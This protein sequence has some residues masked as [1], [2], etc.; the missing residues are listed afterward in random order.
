MSSLVISSNLPSH[1]PTPRSAITRRTCQLVALIFVLSVSSLPGITPQHTC[2]A[3]EVIA[4]K[5]GKQL[6]LLGD[7]LVEAQ[8]GSLLFRTADGKLWIV[9]SDQV[10]SKNE[11]TE[12]VK[13]LSQTAIGE[14]LLKELPD[15]FRIYKTKNFVIAY[16]TE[17]VYA[18]WVGGLYERLFKGFKSYWERKK[19]FKL[20][21]PTFPLTA[22]I[23]SS[24]AEY[25]QYVQR[26][27]GSDPGTMVA[28]YNLMTNRVAMYDLMADQVNPGAQVDNDR[29]V[30]EILSNPN[31]LPMV[32]TVIHE[33]THQLMF[34][35]G[36]QTRF[37][38]TPL[39]INE[40]LAMYFETPDMNSTR[41][42]RAIGRVN[43]LRYRQFR[44]DLPLR[45]ATALENLISSDDRF[46]DQETMLAAYAES[47]ALNYYLLNKRSKE[48]VAYLKHMAKKKP[49]IYD[50]AEQRIE[51]F[52]KFF[53]EDLG[54]LDREFVDYILNLK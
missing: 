36:M 28:Y 20:S 17:K 6:T 5:N 13:P 7:I 39:W 44:N 11:T 18:R 46:K 54:I 22:V 10:V 19:K 32:A 40:G 38:D 8:D 51:E 2:R 29:G 4:K 48:Y 47:W 30:Y 25:A 3:D 52:K 33:G 35:S 14:A 24:R 23:F 21:K 34:N 49:L 27:L 43:L 45:K 26:E 1:L 53:G 31:S 37:S 9:E 16:Q 12:K 50:T 42:W 41:G 15:G